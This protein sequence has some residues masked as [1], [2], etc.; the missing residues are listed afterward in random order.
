M[1][2]TTTSDI[3][4]ITWR[5][6]SDAGIDID[7]VNRQPTTLGADEYILING[8]KK[9]AFAPAKD[10]A[11]RAA[12]GWDIAVYEWMDDD[13]DDPSGYWCHNGQDFARTPADA[14]RLVARAAS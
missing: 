5:M 7:L 10:D 11:G 14:L 8:S 3:T 12:S 2:G 13:P 4:D 6:M 1:T 9:V